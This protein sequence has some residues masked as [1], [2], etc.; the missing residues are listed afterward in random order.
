MNKFLKAG[1]AVFAA[2][3]LAAL[4]ACQ[5]GTSVEL[6][7]DQG[8][9]YSLLDDILAEPSLKAF[10]INNPPEPS[11]WSEKE[12]LNLPDP[13]QKAGGQRINNITEWFPDSANIHSIDSTRGTANL[14]RRE[15][16][17]KIVQHY[18]YGY[19]P[20]PPDHME[21][22]LPGTWNWDSSTSGTITIRMWMGSAAT[23]DEATVK[24]TMSATYTLP[25]VANGN[26]SMYG[27][28]PYPSYTASQ[29]TWGWGQVSMPIGEGS[30]DTTRIGVL[31]P[32]LTANWAT[33]ADA[34]SSL[35]CAAWGF[36]RVLD[37]LDW[38]KDQAEAAGS[39]RY[40][41][42]E[43]TMVTGTSRGGKQAL[44]VGAFA[45]SRRGTKV[46]V[47][48]PNASGAL[49]TSIERFLSPVLNSKMDYY[50][51]VWD[52]GSGTPQGTY[53]VL[54]EDT[55]YTKIYTLGK[56]AKGIGLDQGFQTQH[57]AWT[58]SG[59][60]WP[61]YRNKQFMPLRTDLN[62]DKEG[63]KGYL[64]SIPYDQHFLMALV[65]PRGLLITGGSLD[66]WNNPESNQFG[67]FAVREVYKFLEADKNLGWRWFDVA[68]SAASLKAAEVHEFGDAVNNGYDPDRDRDT[69]KH[70]LTKYRKT[71]VYPIADP[72]STMDYARMYWKAPGSTEKSIREQALEAA[73]YTAP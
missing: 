70:P 14:S 28:G 71:D 62:I 43:W 2:I 11:E 64:G 65:A 41:K 27:E 4:F 50:L 18:E 55:S 32:A 26:N 3:A 31:F 42:P 68:H 40:L 44:V 45:E 69:A 21:F 17:R 1:F 38:A 7:P 48:F 66:Y 12:I 22:S 36:S 25:S 57:H 73:G 5:Q 59:G 13:F 16:I 52:D 23:Y 30:Y 29:P 54:P 35:M 8:G 51:V 19:M 61:S 63:G 6:K 39:T 53:A 58:D 10:D 37:A 60:Y 15:E 72:R 24:V 34:P 9:S 46:G 33:N 67:Y 47:C 20:P 49:G 56:D